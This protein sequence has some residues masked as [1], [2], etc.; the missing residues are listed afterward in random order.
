V[1]SQPNAA[2]MG[3]PETQDPPAPF[4][5]SASY[6]ANSSHAQ[7]A[8]GIRYED[9]PFSQQVETENQQRYAYNQAQRNGFLTDGPYENYLPYINQPAYNIRTTASAVPVAD[10]ISTGDGDPF[11]T[12]DGYTNV[13]NDIPES[14]RPWDSGPTNSWLDDLEPAVWNLIGYSRFIGTSAAGNYVSF[15]DTDGFDNTPLTDELYIEQNLIDFIGTWRD[16]GYTEFTF[17]VGRGTNTLNFNGDNVPDDVLNGG[18]VHFASKD[19]IPAGGA[20]G[21]YAPRLI[22]AIPEPGSATLA[23]LGLIGAVGVRRRTR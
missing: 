20:A 15:G 16:L 23:I 22:L 21:D 17:L 19:L 18:A 13:W 11:T 3:T 14:N 5:G 10:A 1:I 12:G 8:P 2:A 4:P 7:R 9:P 6:G